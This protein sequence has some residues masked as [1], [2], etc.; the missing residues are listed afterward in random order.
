MMLTKEVTESL[1]TKEINCE[2]VWLEDSQ[3]TSGSKYTLQAGTRSVICKIKQI[4]SIIN[5]VSPTVIMPTNELVLNDI[6]NVQL[7]LA[8]PVFIDDFNENKANG[9]FVLID[10]QSNNTVAVGFVKL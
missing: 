4:N 9:A 8:N 5:P 10:N 2:L 1:F 6:G 7:Q 3:A